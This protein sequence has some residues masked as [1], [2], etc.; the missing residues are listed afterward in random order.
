MLQPQDIIVNYYKFYEDVPIYLQRKIIL[1]A[2][3][4]SPNTAKRDNWKRELWY[5]M[6]YQKTDDVLLNEDAFWALWNDYKRVYVFVNQNYLSQFQA[7]ADKSY[8]VGKNN[9]IY[10]LS[11]QPLPAEL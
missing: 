6:P 2:D 8:F 1:V 7:Q 5:A 10:L 4:D 9:D 3:W 11:N